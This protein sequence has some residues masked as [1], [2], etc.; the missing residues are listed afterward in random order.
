LEHYRG[1]IECSVTSAKS[2]PSV[3][4]PSVR[5]VLGV[6]PEAV[7]NLVRMCAVAE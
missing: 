1:K 3:D 6:S 4:G 5:G 7:S 2:V